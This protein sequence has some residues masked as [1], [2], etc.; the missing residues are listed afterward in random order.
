M[1]T[2]PVTE[3]ALRSLLDSQRLAVLATHSAE[4]PYCSLVAFVVSE[5]LRQ[6][7]FATSRNTRKYARLAEDG[8]VALLIDSRENQESDFHNAAAVTV[9]GTAAEVPPE[10]GD[11]VRRTYLARH[12]YLADFLASPSCALLR[13]Q[14]RS[15]ILVDHFQ[16]VMEIQVTP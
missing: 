8:R 3:K 11:T 13:V 6:L 4:G 9:Q 7:V 2:D 5:N 14:V 1:H 10:Q 12:P 16:H 15:Y